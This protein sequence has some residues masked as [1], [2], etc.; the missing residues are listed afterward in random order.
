M[1]NYIPLIMRTISS[2]C[3]DDGRFINLRAA[4]IVGWEDWDT[5]CAMLKN[6]REAIFHIGEAVK[7]SGTECAASP[8]VDCSRGLGMPNKQ[9]SGSRL[10]WEPLFE[11]FVYTNALLAT[12]CLTPRTVLH[13]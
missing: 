9:N 11:A 13:W 8:P 1:R 7:R 12:I 5:V 10:W 3:A 6:D 4:K 2:H